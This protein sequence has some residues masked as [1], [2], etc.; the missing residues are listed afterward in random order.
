MPTILGLGR[1]DPPSRFLVLSILSVLNFDRKIGGQMAASL[2]SR[3][4][5]ALNWLEIVDRPPR[6]SLRLGQPT[7]SGYQQ[8]NL[9]EDSL[10]GIAVGPSL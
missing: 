8:Q 5:E 2:V 6:P 4:E 3:H 1:E 7:P 9:V 10:M